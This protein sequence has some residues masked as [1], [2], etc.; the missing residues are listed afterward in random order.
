MG[1]GSNE[2][3]DIKNLDVN[4]CIVKQGINFII[5]GKIIDKL[6]ESIIRIEYKNAFSTGFFMKINIQEINHNFILTCAHSITKEDINSKNII[7]IYYGKKETEIEKIIELDNNKRFIKSFIDD[8]IDATIIEILHEDDI[9]EDKY[10][11]PDLNYTDGYIQYINKDFYIAGYPNVDVFKREKHFSAGKI[12]GFKYINNNNNDFLHNCS[13]KEG[14]SGSPLINNNLQ[15][16][17]IHYGC[18]KRK[19]S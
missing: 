4:E 13:T 18:N 17:G 7:P 9:P 2:T 16:V 12:L 3:N 15:V 11:Y 6:S 10:L 19:S 5:P 1:C 8:D 14:S